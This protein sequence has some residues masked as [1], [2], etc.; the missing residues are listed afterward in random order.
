M[1]GRDQ[2]GPDPTAE[3]L[4]EVRPPETPWRVDRPPEAAAEQQVAGEPG[5]APGTWQRA[6]TAA[7]AVGQAVPYVQ[8]GAVLGWAAGAAFA[9]DG[10]ESEQP[11]FE[12]GTDG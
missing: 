10:T 5:P 2:A 4:A 11:G 3:W 7:R 8:A 12:P 1:T 6:R 9:E